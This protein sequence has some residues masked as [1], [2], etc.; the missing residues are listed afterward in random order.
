MSNTVPMYAIGIHVGDGNIE[1]G[2][3]DVSGGGVLSRQRVEICPKSDGGT[4][5]ARV[6]DTASTLLT[7]A[8]GF[9]VPVRGIGVSIREIVDRTGKITS[10]HHIAWSDQPVYERLNQ[11]APTTVDSA[12]RCSAL[13]EA[14]YGAGQEYNQFVF[15]LLDAELTS[16]FVQDKVPFSGANG[17]AISFAN[18]SVSVICPECG[19]LYEPVLETFA[20]GAAIAA[21]WNRITGGQARHGEQVLLAAVHDDEVAVEIVHRAGMGVGMAIA[22]IVN[23]LDPEAVVVGGSLGRVGG[24]YWETLVETARQHIRAETSRGLPITPALLDPDAA[25]IGAATR[26]ARHA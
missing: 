2:L 17:N 15:L 6:E 5:L 3:V 24:V 8:K 16:C 20:S 25:I 9:G 23:L 13:A 18:T 12:V 19:T 4:F 1:G 22:W 11:L 26:V 14:H 7:T 21:R 10:D